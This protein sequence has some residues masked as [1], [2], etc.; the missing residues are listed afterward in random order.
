M[1]KEIESDIF[2]EGTI[3]FHKGL[4]VVL[5]DENGTNSI[6]KSNLLMIIDFAFGGNT[7]L[8]YNKDVI[9][10]M[11]DHEVKICFEWGGQ[12]FKYIRRTID[13]DNV[14][15]CDDKYNVIDNMPVKTYTELLKTRYNL[16]N[17]YTTFR[18]LVSTYSRI[19]GKNNYSV[20][21]PLHS[22]SKANTQEMIDNLIKLFNMYDELYE[23]NNIIKIEKEKL[24]ALQKAEQYNHLPNIT[25]H[26]YKENTKRIDELNIEIEQIQDQL[27][28][29]TINIRGLINDDIININSQKSKLIEKKAIYMNKLKR[30]ET[31]SLKKNSISLKQL[32][33]LKSIFPNSNTKELDEIND[34]HIKI[35]DYLSESL[36]KEKKEIEEKLLVINE[37][38]KILDEKIEER[39]S[40]KEVP[41]Q[42]PNYIIKHLL[43]LNDSIHKRRE[44]NSFYEKK[45]GIKK[46]IDDNMLTFRENK[47]RILKQIKQ[48]LNDEMK[49]VNANIEGDKVKSPEIIFDKSKYIFNTY[50][51]TGTGNA[52]QGIIVLD[53]AIFGITNLPFIIHDSVLFNNISD[54]TMQNL[55]KLYSTYDKQIFI[56]LDRVK[57]YAL[58]YRKILI[59]NKVIK[60][61]KKQ[62]LFKK[63]WN[64]KLE[65]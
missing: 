58:P 14:F 55:I 57:R 12:E 47:T 63:I 32:E 54:D 20:E 15:I 27:R 13:K 34:F 8:S 2:R 59:N 31:N 45:C 21:Q 46:K 41:E 64:R 26:K 23:Q 18:A 25:A 7:Y 43:E 38:I 48:Q 42:I 19:W 44:E 40:I 17:N 39:L 35:C 28:L 9:K 22:F 52:Y 61:D 60:L 65:E 36:K 4:N 50:E 29:L 62:T 37:D 56:A 33:K 3:K 10:N 30:I 11:G 1:L 5:G 49:I 24:S 16:N 6:G 53:L 51:D